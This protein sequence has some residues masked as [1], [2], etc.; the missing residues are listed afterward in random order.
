MSEPSAHPI[1]SI[2]VESQ[3][4]PGY[5]LLQ[6]RT[7]TERPGLDNL[8]ELPQGHVH[9]GESI[10]DCAARELAE[11][12]GLAPFEL[13]TPM[14][15]VTIASEQ[16]MFTTAATVVSET[17]HHSYVAV[18]LVGSAPGSPRPSDESTDPRWYAREEVVALIE[19][20]AIYPL[21]VPML[22]AYYGV[23]L[24]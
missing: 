16:L 9:Q 20:D 21:N 7:K 5:I 12:T 4:R 3:D 24:A 14:K 13:R 11:E 17:G 22:S 6:R 18:C 19:S 15:R 1:V 10:A 8:L 23:P 2:I